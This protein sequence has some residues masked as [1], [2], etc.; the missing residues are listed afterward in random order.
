MSATPYCVGCEGNSRFI[1]ASADAFESVLEEYFCGGAWSQDSS[2]PRRVP[3]LVQSE[4]PRALGAAEV[5]G[6]F[7]VFIATCFG[8]KIF[9]EFYER[10]LK[11][12]LAPFLDQLCRNE[13]VSA[14]GSVEIRDVVYLSDIDT[15]VVVRAVVTS[16]TAAETARLFLQAHRVAHAYLVQHGRKAP[17][18]CHTIGDGKVSIEPELFLSLEHL[19]RA[20]REVTRAS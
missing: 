11:R 3:S 5:A 4:R 2:L 20:A 18:H 9:D 12:P 10:L 16:E 15:T 19:A 13:A 17:L 1:R 7:V 8:K 14:K 6:A